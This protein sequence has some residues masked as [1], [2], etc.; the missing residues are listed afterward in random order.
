M[1][2]VAIICSVGRT[3]W[4]FVGLRAFG[5]SNS[6]LPTDAKAPAFWP[7]DQIVI[8]DLESEEYRKLSATRLSKVRQFVSSG[9][10]HSSIFKAAISSIP[11]WGFARELNKEPKDEGADS[12]SGE[13]F[14]YVSVAK[15]LRGLARAQKGFPEEARKIF[16]GANVLTEFLV[17][18]EPDRAV[19]RLEIWRSVVT[20]YTWKTG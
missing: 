10:F 2:F 1:P 11:R 18:R 19:I 13:E 7:G 20:F 4:Y 9:D 5:L 17:N 8:N 6:M 12:D 14:A 3:S 15:K 16:K